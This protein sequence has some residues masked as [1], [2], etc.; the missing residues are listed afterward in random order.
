MKR[1]FT[2]FATMCFVMGTSNV[3][4]TDITTH[5]TTSQTLTLSGSPYNIINNININDGVTITIE[6]GVEIR[7]NQGR[8][9]QVFGTL[10]ATGVTFTANTDSPTKGFWDAIYVGY[11]G[12]SYVANITLD[13]CVVEYA[14]RIHVRKGNLELKG[15]TIIQ[16]LNNYGLDIYQ[17]G[18][19]DMENTTITACSYPVYFRDNVAGGFVT[20]NG[21]DL[22]GN[23]NDYVFL[24]FYQVTSAIT[25]NDLGIPYYYDS[26][27]R[28]TETGELTIGPG[29]K[30]EGHNGALFNVFG[31]IKAN[32][33]AE[34]PIEFYKYPAASY[35]Q[36]LNIQNHDFDAEN[37]L[38]YCE[39]KDVLYNDINRSAVDI[40][41]SSPTLDHC[42]FSNNIYN[43]YARGTSEP[44]ITNSLFGASVQNSANPYNINID[45]NAIPIFTDND[46]SFNASEAQAIG[47]VGS[48]I[49]RDSELPQQ[50]FNGI[51]NI[52]YLL[53]G[54]VTVH[55]TASLTIE[56]GVVIK[57]QRNSDYFYGNGVING[58]GTED[59]PIIFTFRED[60][61]Y[62]NP[63]DTY[64]NG[65]TTVGASSGGRIIVYSQATSRLEHWKILYAGYTSNY[66]AVYLSNG[67]VLSNCEIS[68]AYRAVYF[69][70][71]AQVINNTFKDI[72]YYPITRNL[73]GGS[74]SLVNNSLDNVGNTGIYVYGF[75][76][77]TYTISGLD[78]ASNQ[79]VAYIMDNN[80]DIPEG[81][82]VTIAPGTIIKFNGGSILVRGGLNATGT[83][84]NKVIFTSIH[85]DS[86][87]GDTN[88]NGTGSSP[89]AYNWYGIA[90]FPS[91]N[92]SFN[93]LKNCEVR[94]S[95]YAYDV[96]PKY[97]GSI[98]M[99]DCKV[100]IDSTLINFSNT[101]ALAIY[102]SANPE[103][104]N[105]E[106][107]NLDS[108]PV[109]MD[110]FANPT[111]ANNTVANVPNN[112]ISLRGQTVAG[113][114]PIRSFN[115][116]DTIT[117]ILREDMT[118]N[119]ELIIPAGLTF[120]SDR[121]MNWNING[122]I[123]VNGSAQHPVIF[124][125]FQDDAYGQ[126]ADLQGNGVT[127]ISNN[128]CYFVFSDQADDASTVNFATFRYCR[129]DAIQCNNASPTI[130]NCRFENYGNTGVSL[131][132]S[133]MP[134]MNSCIFNNISYP[135][136]TSLVS[137]F[138]STSGNQ[139]TGSTGRA[140]RVR[141]E[142]LSQ[143]VTLETR[144][145]AGITSIPYVFYQYTVGN[146][147]ILTLEE[148]VVCKFQQ[149]GYITVR[150]G[151]MVNGGDSP[152]TAVVFT[153]DKDDF[154]GG[155]TYNNG[156]ADLPND[157]YW[158]GIYFAGEAIDASCVIEN[159]VFKH[160]TYR[161]TNNPNGNNRGAIT[162]QDASP[163]IN[164]CLFEHNY[165]GIIAKG[166][167]SPE[168]SSCDFV[169]TDPTNGYGV[170][171]DSG[172][173]EV[174]A[175][176]CWWNSN[177]GPEHSSNPNGEGERV[178]DKVNFTPFATQLAKPALGD[179]SLNGE[180][181][182]YDAALVLQHAAQGNVLDAKQQGVADVSGNG[183][184]TSFDASLILQYSIGLITMFDQA[185]TK[186]GALLDASIR[187]DYST[188]Y[189]ESK[190]FTVPVFISTSNKVTALD[191]SFHSN[192][193]HLK[194]VKAETGNLRS[195]IAVATGYNS[196]SGE[197]KISMAS[198][199][200]LNMNNNEI[201]LIFELQDG[202]LTQST[203]ELVEILAN[204]QTME[205]PL[206][207]TIN[208]A[209][210][211]GFDLPLALTSFKLYS[212]NQLCH[213]ELGL[214]EA[215]SNVQ[216]VFMD[217]SGKVT[218]LLN[219]KQPV[220]GL[221]NITSP[222]V[223]SGM[224][225]SPGIYLVTVTGDNFAVT[226]KVIVR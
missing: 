37:V 176:N 164:N 174:D 9:L 99:S 128:G 87:S 114:I 16:N 3:R 79:N 123:M 116:H 76:E 211:T 221:H 178:S 36:G 139:I 26:E 156:D 107:F 166:E 217:L 137:Y 62:G 169:N 120:K 96:V 103:V 29:A 88:N 199:Y 74:P 5:F 53:N 77:G 1:I 108:E 153:A 61:D 24:N 113:T 42:S 119:D 209:T 67:N 80:L 204:E 149:N 102:G 146:S 89:S 215:Q 48:T 196:E 185:G 136:R 68:D 225:A 31:I 126:P 52:T 223:Q 30:F 200:D 95:G 160:G 4:A 172:E 142:T 171:K 10:N 180:I 187:S 73:N 50:S 93:K 213:I 218:H 197:I 177:T 59:E 2:F 159:A 57:C 97:A 127:N 173:S 40:I 105:S 110:M 21:I 125:S 44:V 208:S 151:L 34:N 147:S 22:S 219:L 148:G 165:W 101:N 212:Q 132:G 38:S 181:K 18:S 118:I 58:I 124:T 135:F 112:G 111:F 33:T 222:V 41:N 69:T 12:Y 8:Y 134:E 54:Q 198:A 65:A 175:L 186:S 63:K 19:V 46:I 11:Q 190:Q 195:N 207:I 122:K 210:A 117:Y 39:F 140:I 70:D 193:Q 162:T 167:S 60:D 121:D 226:R 91:S 84:N 141:D 205:N 184:I 106:F 188:I 55:D 45:L 94:Y 133:S 104:T 206:S 86:A 214:T 85:D 109:H 192:V 51:E 98:R 17:A 20:G 170:W 145:F 157:Y 78:F 220:A 64:Q 49:I 202:P 92:D 66:Y 183:S 115:G 28:V 56:A 6:E 161:Y 100:V 155:D 7:F 14:D 189:P 32:G 71:D 82:N 138:S 158:Q 43:F 47:I 163:T 75:S 150:K 194:L 23:T 182:P 216:V 13:N 81:T 179:V 191:I 143:D 224:N 152:E 83:K 201:Q 25:L 15:S 72:N 130:N 131:T 144:S 35:W 203:I 154:Y 129:T 168:I 90:F 27:L